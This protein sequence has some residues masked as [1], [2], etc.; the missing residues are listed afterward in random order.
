MWMAYFASLLVL[1]FYGFAFCEFKEPSKLLYSIIL[2]KSDQYCVIVFE[3]KSFRCF[4]NC[5]NFPVDSN[6]ER[7]NCP[8]AYSLYHTYQ[9]NQ[10][11]CEFFWEP[12]KIHTHF[13][14]VFI[15][16]IRFDC[17][18]HKL[19][20]PAIWGKDKLPAPLSVTVPDKIISDLLTLSW[21]IISGVC[22]CLL[23]W[24]NKEIF[25]CEVYQVFFLR[26]EM[27][28]EGKTFSM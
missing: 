16:G 14:V 12:G 20:S 5:S 15:N 7:L 25:P 24:Q 1:F 2:Y 6:T 9:F 21:K 11:K 3:E 8:I 10:K 19:A 26:G 4:C 17:G 18:H 27:E 28:L 13:L 23:W 22:S